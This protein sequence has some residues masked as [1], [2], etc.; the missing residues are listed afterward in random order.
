MYTPHGCHKSS[1]LV[2]VLALEQQ[3]LLKAERSGWLADWLVTG[4]VGCS[5]HGATFI[6]FQGRSGGRHDARSRQGKE[7]EEGCVS[8][9]YMLFMLQFSLL[10]SRIMIN[11]QIYS[12]ASESE[13]GERGEGAV[14]G[15]A[16]VE[17]WVGWCWSGGGRGGR[18]V[19]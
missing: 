4:V 14:G 18:G 7:E 10:Y 8:P 1:F 16:E 3:R 5:L 6:A 17:G 2:L 9:D 13:V 11:Q 15:G 12:P 19:T